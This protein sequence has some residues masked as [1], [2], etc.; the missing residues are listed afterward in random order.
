MTLKKQLNSYG[1]NPIF[2]QLK[3]RRLILVVFVL[4]TYTEAARIACL[5]AIVSKLV[6]VNVCG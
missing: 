3:S 1:T 2:Y 4:S 6:G 5:T